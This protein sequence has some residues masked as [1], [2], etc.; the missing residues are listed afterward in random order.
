MGTTENNQDIK[1]FVPY[2]KS[3]IP[4]SVDTNWNHIFRPKHFNI[5]HHESDIDNEELLVFKYMPAKRIINNIENNEFVFVSPAKWRDPFETIFYDSN[6]KINDKYVNVKAACFA[7]N[8]FKNEEGLWHFSPFSTPE[9]DN[10]TVR[11]A[12]KMEKLLDALEKYANERNHHR[13][14]FYISDMSYMDYSLSK[15]I[16]KEKRDN[17]INSIGD[18]IDLLC[19]KRIAYKHEME[20]R[21]FAVQESDSQI[22]DKDDLLRIP[23]IDMSKVISHITLPPID[24]MIDGERLCED[25]Y[26]INL[27]AS[28]KKTK[29]KLEALNIRFDYSRL[30]DLKTFN[31]FLQL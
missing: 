1:N 7:L 9:E 20:L 14:N 31:N 3:L 22:K 25:C 13:T 16:I 30:Y 29:K 6:L 27:E 12:F 21:L 11:V 2:D 19:Y 28:N 24:T 17:L 8:D 23:N 18:Y 10:P 15:Q 5:R 26:K 4:M